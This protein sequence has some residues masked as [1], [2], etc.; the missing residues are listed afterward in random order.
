MLARIAG[1]QKILSTMVD[2][3]L[4]KLEAHLRRELDEVLDREETLWY[5]KSRIDWLKN[6]DR[7][8]TFFHL[9]TI[10]RRWKNK[11]TSIKNNEGVW[12]QNKEDIKNHIVDYFTSLFQA[13][14]EPDSFDVPT[15]I[16]P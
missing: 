16:F 8:T 14:E 10:I 4:I 9:S 5:Q 15:D 6:G 2:R 13:D 12:L 7:N 3:G 11:I 1:V